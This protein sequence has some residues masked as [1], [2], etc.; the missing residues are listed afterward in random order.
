M[1]THKA[2]GEILHV[3][4]KQANVIL[5]ILDARDPEG[6][7]PHKV[8]E[9]I[10][11]R[12]ADK[13]LFLVLNKQDMVPEDVVNAWSAYYQQQ[14]FTCFHASAAKKEG[15]N[16]LLGQ[17]LRYVDHSAPAKILI[18]GYP[19]TGKSSIINAILK[20]KKTAR[21]SP[22]AGFTRGIQMLKIE[23]FAQLY[24]LDSPG[25]VPYD[26]EESE[27]ALALKAAV[28]I[29]KI[30]DPEAVFDEIY[31]KAGPEKLAQVYEIEFADQ[32]DFLEKL[33][34][35]R[36]RLLKGGVVNEREVWLLVIRDWQR[37]FIPYY[38]IP[39]NYLG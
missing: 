19:N 1:Q 22:E 39:P 25:V 30:K 9:F 5:E 23:G 32:A 29:S 36:G 6:T 38:T 8:E 13:K 18:V 20:D 28:K 7:R 11:E 33:G 10:Q 12:G 2:W 26:E 27:L 35:K 21:T 14:G 15:T 16:F 37:N 4:E 31:R 17:I 24:L 3:I 34:R